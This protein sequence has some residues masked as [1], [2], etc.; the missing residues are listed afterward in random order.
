MH[1]HQNDVIVRVQ[2]QQLSAKRR[3]IADLERAPRFVSGKLQSS[4][5]TF[6]RV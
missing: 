4:E 6:V 2:S 1:A 3:L 5:L